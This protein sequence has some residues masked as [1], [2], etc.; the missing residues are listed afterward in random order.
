LALRESGVVDMRSVANGRDQLENG[1]LHRFAEALD[2]SLP[3]VA[4]GCYTIWDSDGAY[5]Y[6]GMAGRKMTVAS[7][8]A[9]R[10]N[11][12][13][14]P[15][16]LLSR[17]RSHQNGRR[18]GDQFCVYVFDLFVLPGLTSADVADVVRRLRRLDDDVRAFVQG[19]LSYRWCETADATSAFELERSLVT[20]G[21]GGV[22]PFINPRRPEES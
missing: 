21:M 2:P 4:A 3:R 19:Q 17:L 6:A 12:L 5:L 8:A 13:A 7:I 11:P 10:T 1:S 20:D 16:G 14:K 9:A 18:S 22:L 15:S